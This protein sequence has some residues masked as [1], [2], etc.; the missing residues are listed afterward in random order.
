MLDLGS[1]CSVLQFLVIA[2]LL[3]LLI[4]IRICGNAFFL[5]LSRNENDQM[6]SIVR[7]TVDSTT[8][9]EN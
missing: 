9:T 7:L 8:L 3:L 2:Y 4:A 5:F 6:T 1:D